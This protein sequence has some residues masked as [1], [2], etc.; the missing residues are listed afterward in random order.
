MPRYF[1]HR[2]IDDRMVWDRAGL[3]L[4]NLRMAPWAN[5]I[6]RKLQPGQVLLVT[7]AE[8]QLLFVT[9]R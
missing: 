1:F 6:S 7:D 4:P 2:C 5:I 9:A 8:G 3:E